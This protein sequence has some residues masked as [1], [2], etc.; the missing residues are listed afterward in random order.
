M[1][2]HQGNYL[3]AIAIIAIMF[4]APAQSFI[5]GSE[6]NPQWQQRFPFIHDEV[7]FSETYESVRVEE[8]SKGSIELLDT[9]KYLKKMKLMMPGT[10]RE[11]K[12]H[13]SDR[14]SVGSLA[15]DLGTHYD[16]SNSS[17]ECL[18]GAVGDIMYINKGTDNF[19][20][21]P[22]AAKLGP[23]DVLFGNI[24]TPVVPGIKPSM[25]HKFGL[26]FNAATTL[27]DTLAT[28]GKLSHFTEDEQPVFD[29][30]SVTNN[31]SFDLEEQGLKT[32]M[33]EIASRGMLPV[34]VAT[35]FKEGDDRG[36]YTI[37]ERNGYKI[38]FVA[39]SWGFNKATLS[40]EP[41]E[42][43]NHLPFGIRS[44]I[45]SLTPFTR[46]LRKARREGADFVVASVHWGYEYE[47]FPEPHF[48]KIARLLAAGGADM[49]VGHGPHVL[50]PIEILHVNMPEYRDTNHFVEDFTDR[51]PRT[52][53][54]AYSLGNFT[55]AMSPIP[56]RIGG[57]LSVGLTRGIHKGSGIERC[58]ISKAGLSLIF[59][60]QRGNNLLGK[61]VVLRDIDW[62][63]SR[64]NDD[65]KL[66]AL[67][68]QGLEKIDIERLGLQWLRPIGQE[69]P[70][71]DGTNSHDHNEPEPSEYAAT[72]DEYEIHS[73]NGDLNENS[74][75]NGYNSEET[76][77]K[78]L[79]S[80]RLTPQATST[81]CRGV[82]SVESFENL[83]DEPLP[84]SLLKYLGRGGKTI[85]VSTNKSIGFGRDISTIVE[86]KQDEDGSFKTELFTINGK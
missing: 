71:H 19:I 25:V 86:I 78:V 76:C 15:L 8:A 44:S 83:S 56:C 1:F 16:F 75:L 5:Y 21:P 4:L 45:P 74:C 65:A 7:P 40:G 84:L 57:L 62:A 39:F 66:E 70:N 26:R 38:G 49:V 47:Y 17:G 63:L 81:G 28:G 6:D 12:K 42:Y 10:S 31:H 14:N 73:T 22:L 60:Q 9:A 64:E 36:K 41:P 37:V 48:M 24:E 69:Y 55:T 68:D 80:G 18:L 23:V 61:K 59:N 3:K 27:L 32:T 11:V 29:V 13:F 33:F 85:P 20:R 34:G 30:L 43:I 53:L 51:A 35:S 77:H 46:L 82:L 52:S 58:L 67:V 50:Q 72:D 2:Y 79:I 54:I